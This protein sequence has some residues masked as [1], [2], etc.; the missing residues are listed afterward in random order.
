MS[1]FILAQ[2][3]N[4]RSVFSDFNGDG[5]ADLAVVSTLPGYVN[6]FQNAG[7][8]ENWQATR[9]IYASA[10][11]TYCLAAGDLD[12]DGRTDMAAADNGGTTI[13]IFRNKSSYSTIDFD[14]MGIPSVSNPYGIAIHD[15]DG[16]GRRD[17]VVTSQQSGSMVWVYRNTGVGDTIRFADGVAVASLSASFAAIVADVDGDGKEDILAASAGDNSVV[18]VR[19]LSTP[20]SLQFASQQ[21]FSTGSYPVYVALGDLDGDGKPD[22]ATANRFGNSVSVLRNLSVPGL[23]QFATQVEYAVGPHPLHVMIGDLDGDGAPDLAS[24]NSSDSSVSLLKNIHGLDIT[25]K[26]ISFNP[27]SASENGVVQIKGSNLGAATAVQFGG[28]D[29]KSFIK[30]GDTLITATVGKG[31]TG[32]VKIFT[33]TGDVSKSGFVY[34]GP[35][36]S[37]FAPVSANTGETVF[38]S[39]NNFVNVTGVEFGGVAAKSFTVI[40]TTL[41]EAVVG[42]GATGVVKVHTN[43]GTAELDGFSFGKPEIQ[44]FYPQSGFVFSQVM[45]HTKNAH[46]VADSNL[47]QFGGIKARVISLKGDT[48]N[49]EVPVGSTFKPITLTVRGLVATSSQSFTPTFAND[50]IEI[51]TQSFASFGNYQVG[52]YPRAI[53]S[54]DFDGDGKPDLVT[55]NA[56]SNSISVLKNLSVPGAPMFGAAKHFATG[57]SPMR[58]QVADLD[59]DGRNDVIVTNFN[60]GMSGSVSVLRNTSSVNNISFAPK[61]DLQT[62]N[63]SIGV[64][65][66][67]FNND[68][69]ADIVVA[70]G[71]SAAMYVFINNSSATTG[72]NFNAPVIINTG[73]QLNNIIAVDINNDRKPDLVGT[74]SDNNAMVVYRNLSENGAVSFD[75]QMGFNTGGFPGALAAADLDHNGYTDIVVSNF[76]AGTATVWYNLS[77]EYYVNFTEKQT[78]KLNSTVPVFADLNGDGETELIS[79][80]YVDGRISILQNRISPFQSTPFVD[81]VSFSAGSYDSYVATGDFDGDGKVDIAVSNASSSAVRILRNRFAD[82]KIYN[83]SPSSG[84]TGDKIT[85]TGLGFSS[86]N[87]VSFGGT[88]VQSFKIVSDRIVE[89]V[90]AE[91][92][93]GAIRL[94]GTKGFV[95]ASQFRFVPSITAQGKLSICGGDSVILRSSDNKN[96][97]WYR[98]GSLIT[99]ATAQT[100][101]ARQPGEYSVRTK[102]DTMLIESSNKIIVQVITV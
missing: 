102:L 99:G 78:F 58:M 85:I 14:T 22:V 80:K 74:R 10:S 4:E 60:S 67:D 61:V 46:P 28:L 86:M 76:S 98:S 87:S 50:S 49:V 82:P 6:V 92:S 19:N 90:L 77:A 100:Y 16:D 34:T 27:A 95:E 51:S 12:N 41:I 26:I 83:F 94:S 93:S 63:G 101:I 48:L 72:L 68:G 17:I 71:N 52:S 66:A 20:G 84:G 39:G 21:N 31:N 7:P 9:K 96:N 15:M 45:L 36:M 64:A 43:Q 42:N 53:E 70:S 33:P 44:S 79:G 29:A 3:N 89:A 30:S 40:S 73:G 47:V 55:A 62:G 57:N 65:V 35:A 11:G 32:D 56:N 8:L 81:S 37:G 54:V 38:I 75:Y 13:R 18:V 91:G 2:N 24:A 59:G 69:R 97:Q 25:P 1:K 88:A 23:I 5:R